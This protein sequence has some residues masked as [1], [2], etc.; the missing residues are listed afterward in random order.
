M[1]I[2]ASDWHLGYRD[3]VYPDQYADF[4]KQEAI[5]K[6]LNLCENDEKLTDLVLVG[7]ILDFWRR[8]NCELF[9]I[10]Q[11]YYDQMKNFKQILNYSVR[12]RVGVDIKGFDPTIQKIFNNQEI[13]YKLGTL[14]Q[15][16][17]VHYVIG[18]HDYYLL[19]LYERN[20][21]YFP[22]MVT[23]NLRLRNPS[24][25]DK[26]YYFT[27]GYE[28][29]VLANY[30]TLWDI[31][32]YEKIAERLCHSNNKTGAAFSSIYGA[33]E[34]LSFRSL[35]RGIRQIQKPVYQR[36]KEI[37]RDN[38]T[39]TD[40]FAQ[41]KAEYLMLGMNPSDVLIYGHTHVPYV[42][43]TMTVA[44]TGSWCNDCPGKDQ[45]TYLWIEGNTI[46]QKCITPT[47]TI[48]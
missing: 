8:S 39:F 16:V 13:L 28:M 22:F 9:S 43:D 19:K 26:G 5:L 46:I 20:P 25:P 36:R 29:D 30:E 45:F 48:L 41:S 7:D 6:F 14:P 33:F 21:S 44:N 31:D 35:G 42:D 40:L 12:R 24:D 37:T 18:N 11:H 27:H 38:F 15:K 34:R 10:P 3:N 1:I 4:T 23:K 17:Q 47:T 2:A 32:Q